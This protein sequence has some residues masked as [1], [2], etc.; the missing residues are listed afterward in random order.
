MYE[1]VIFRNDIDIEEESFNKC[2][3]FI[4]FVIFYIYMYIFLDE[5]VK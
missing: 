3:F 2:F 4:E 1:N 5:F